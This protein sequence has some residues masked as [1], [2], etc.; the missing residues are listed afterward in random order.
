[1]LTPQEKAEFLLT[2]IEEDVDRMTVDHAREFLAIVADK[3]T[4]MAA[5][6]GD[7]W[8][9]FNTETGDLEHVKDPYDVPGTIS[10]HAGIVQVRKGELPDPIVRFVDDDW[11]DC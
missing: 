11:A 8:I 7:T 2:E 10:S 6:L 9:I 5:S 1:M 4:R 3:V